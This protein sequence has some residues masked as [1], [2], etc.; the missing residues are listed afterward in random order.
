MTQFKFIGG[1]IDGQVRFND[2]RAYSW[3]VGFREFTDNGDIRVLFDEFNFVRPYEEFKRFRDTMQKE[4]W[5][6]VY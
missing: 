2:G 3:T 6:L 5:E 1:C 4:G